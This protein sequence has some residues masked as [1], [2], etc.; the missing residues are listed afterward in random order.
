MKNK[1]NIQLIII[2]TTCLVLSS[3]GSSVPRN[4]LQNLPSLI[5]IMGIDLA[6]GELKIR[7]SHRNR[8]T[9]KNNQLSCQLALK[10]YTPIKFNQIQLPDLTNYA[11]ET[12][13]IKLSTIDLPVVDSEHKQMPY[14]LDCYLFSET[15][16]E[17]H[18]IKKSTLFRVPGS[19]AEYR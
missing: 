9:R 19:T 6:D 10:D 12:I 8:L 4:E 11:V 2:I 13:D 14:V 7:I 16:R 5:E 1:L 15:F 17:E 3:C 18:L